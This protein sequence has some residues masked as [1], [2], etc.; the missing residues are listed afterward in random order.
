LEPQK[1]AW[2]EAAAVSIN[3]PSDIV[4]DVAR[5]ADPARSSEA[6]QRLTRLAGQADQVAA[7][8]SAKF[9][10]VLSN[11]PPPA[12][13][14]TRN[15]RTQLAH[16]AELTQ[17]GAQSVDPK[18]QALRKFEA[19]VLQNLVETMLPNNE[20][21]FGEGTAGM[22][23]KSMMAQELGSDLAKKVDLGIA[24]KHKIH[25]A[26]PRGAASAQPLTTFI[27]VPPPT[28]S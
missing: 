19:L 5:A 4:L 14:A 24:S 12:A 9:T 15:L 23:W 2:R 26:A 8:G 22:V 28:R 10:E 21:F 17:K 20:E 27:G 11:V 7:T 6:T 1:W 16:S 25:A 13:A 3:P 18:T